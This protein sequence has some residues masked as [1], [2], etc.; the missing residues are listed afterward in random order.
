MTDK[1]TVL[2]VD[3]HPM[4]CALL[5]TLVEDDNSLE[6]CGEAAGVA[7]ALTMAEQQRPD[8][9]IVDISLGDGNGI[10]LLKKLL[11]RQPEM[12]ILVCSTHDEAVFA[13][14]VL[15]AGALGFISKRADHEQIVEALK[16]IMKGEQWVSPEQKDRLDAIGSNE[17]IGVSSLSDRELEVLRLIAQGMTPSK[18]AE[19][20]H[21]SV[22]TVD[23]HREKI[24]RKLGMSSASEL[25]RYA[26]QW[27]LEEG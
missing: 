15:D 16:T 12:S 22:K 20:L 26:V 2:I 21:L 19:Q 27:S 14:R 18:M 24:K 9:A 5:S 17:I 13:P 6:V 23:A 4:V 25:L 10:D 7:E 11:R 1:K 8:V 3:D